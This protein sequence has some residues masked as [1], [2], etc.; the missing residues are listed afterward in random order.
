MSNIPLTVTQFVG[1]ISGS[2]SVFKYSNIVTPVYP[3][4]YNITTPSG[5]VYTQLIRSRY[6][7]PRGGSWVFEQTPRLITEHVTDPLGVFVVLLVAILMCVASTGVWPLLVRLRRMTAD[8]LENLKIIERN[9]VKQMKREGLDAETSR[10]NKYGAFDLIWLV[11]SFVCLFFVSMIA[12]QMVCVSLGWP[13][14]SKTVSRGECLD[15]MD[16]STERSLHDD[17]R[18]QETQATWEMKNKTVRFYSGC[19]RSYV[20]IG[21]HATWR[22]QPYLN[23]TCKSVP[24]V[25]ITERG[26]WLQRKCGKVGSWKTRSSGLSGDNVIDIWTGRNATNKQTPSSVLSWF[27]LYGNVVDDVSKLI[28]KESS[29]VWYPGGQCGW[30]FADWRH[31]GAL[32]VRY[33]NESGWSECQWDATSSLSGYINAGAGLLKREN[34]THVEDVPVRDVSVQ[35]SRE[36]WK[37]WYEH[38]DG[39]VVVATDEFDRGRGSNMYFGE[40][41]NRYM[42]SMLQMQHVLPSSYMPTFTES[43]R[44]VNWKSDPWI[45]RQTF[46]LSEEYSNKFIEFKPP[47]LSVKIVQDEQFTITNNNKDVSCTLKISTSPDLSNPQTVVLDQSPLRIP[48]VYGWNCVNRDDGVGVDCNATNMSVV[49]PDVIESE[50]TTNTTNV[51]FSGDMESGFDV[52]GEF[53]LFKPPSFHISNTA[54]LCVYIAAGVLG[55][56]LICLVVWGVYRCWRKNVAAD[57]VEKV[58]VKRDGEVDL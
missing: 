51:W 28:R 20:R 33:V 48:R 7:C 45:C 2:P 54:M 17:E 22:L 53:E 29:D 5:V 46:T 15:L 21:E 18:E 49:H 26:T 27:P 39:R 9:Q 24:A 23:K 42:I 30:I 1:N 50:T 19:G 57:I 38:A 8:I 31:R 55:V 11:V 40:Y 36:G 37:K 47:C 44:N 13:N 43:M 4:G 14:V 6:L 35:N 56:L 52:F 25:R 12:A 10:V 58:I 34:G 41:A 3:Y 16:T 32:Q